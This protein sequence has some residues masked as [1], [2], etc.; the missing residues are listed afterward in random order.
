MRRQHNMTNSQDITVTEGRAKKAVDSLTTELMMP[1]VN[2]KVKTAVKE[3]RIKTGVITKFYPYLDKAEVKL[4]TNNQKILCKILHR[5]G[6]DLIDFYTP[7]GESNFCET[8]K[9]PCIIPKAEQH[10]CVLNIHDKDSDESIILGYYQNEELMGFDPASPGNMKL[11]S[12]TEP[13]EYWLQFG[14]DG[15]DLRVPKKVTTEVGILPNEMTPVNHYTTDETYSKEKKN[16]PSLGQIIENDGKKG[17][18]ISVDMFKRTYKV[19]LTDG[20]IIVV[21]DEG[22]K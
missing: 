14:A 5:F 6:G 7:R 3:E 19:A 1:K 13:N 11:E 12:L 15:L 16:Y 8:L 9:E 17:K 4:D 10:V 2:D 21:N 18:V 22:K 20:D